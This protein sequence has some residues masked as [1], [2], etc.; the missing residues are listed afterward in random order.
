MVTLA[1]SFCSFDKRRVIG[2]M[3]AR[4]CLAYGFQLLDI[5]LEEDLWVSIYG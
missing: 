3:T 1:L 5:L 2:K 4:V